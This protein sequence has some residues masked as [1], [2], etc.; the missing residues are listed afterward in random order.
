MDFN[1]F[2]VLNQNL[3]SPIGN[4][5]GSIL[6]LIIGGGVAKGVR[7]AIK[8]GLAKTNLDG[9]F[10]TTA[11]IGSFSTMLADV[12]YW[13]VL[14]M[15][16]T[17][18]SGKL[19]LTG[20]FNPLTNMLDKI[21]DFIPHVLTAGVIFFVGSIIA[22]ILKNIS[23][24]LVAGLNL[25]RLIVHADSS[26]GKL[27]EMVGAVVFLLVMIPFAIA[28][29]D[30]LKIDSISRPATNMLNNILE[31]LPSIFTAT[32]ILAT[33]YYVMRAIV[34]V[35]KML[36]QAT[37]ID[38]IPTKLGLQTALGASKVSDIITGIMMVFAMLFASIVVA[39]LL[40]FDQIGV[41]IGVF[42]N[43]GAQ[44]ILGVVILAIGFWLANGVAVTVEHSQKGSVLL[45]NITR[46]LI[47]GLVL[48]MGLKAMGIADSIVNLA[49]GLTLGAIAV[50]FAL[51]FG[52]GGREA[53]ARYL[54]NL[55]DK[56][57][58]PH[59][60]NSYPPKDDRLQ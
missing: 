2:A 27:S 15:V 4:I 36:L 26:N 52:L 31:A 38:S 24:G 11:N 54:A 25:Q 47:T 1:Q 55:Q 5:I 41:L 7:I 46:T 42:I 48:A 45:A 44:I 21:L 29:L 57:G 20:I 8:T 40:G 17:M 30:A 14:L 60:K 22:R 34:N 35:V 16:L 58:V 33:T 18:V 6:I 3:S 23:M 9:K 50:A 32:A 49:F 19:G 59:Q 10:A 56:L 39:E 37:V 43:F 28:G 12:V 13:F 51:A 53:A